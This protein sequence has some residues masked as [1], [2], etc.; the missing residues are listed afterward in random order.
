M[1][2]GMYLYFWMIRIVA[3]VFLCCTVV[4]IPSMV[5]N[6]EVRAGRGGG[7]LISKQG[8]PSCFSLELFRSGHIFAPKSFSRR[9]IVGA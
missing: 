5:L 8:Y 1:G 9:K 6:A 7:R 2:V 4:S 3:I